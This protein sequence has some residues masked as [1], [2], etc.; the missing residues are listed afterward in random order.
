MASSADIVL[1]LHT[2]PVATRYVYSPEYLKD[3]CSD[4][5]FPHYILIPNEFGGAMDEATFNPWVKLYEKLKDKGIV[6]KHLFEAYTVEL[7]CEEYICM[8]DAEVDADNILNLL[9]K[10]G[11]LIDYDEDVIIPEMHYCPLKD[12]KM[13]RAPHSGLLEYHVA[14]GESFEKNEVLATLYRFDKLEDLEASQTEIRANTRGIVI[15]HIPTS[16]VKMGMDIIECF[17]Y[18][19]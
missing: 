17:T 7:G 6:L 14:P 18:T 8:E 19:S 2:G 11:V 10:R 5:N 1:D 13:Y 3:I 12:Y 4:I 15:N 16:N 9:S